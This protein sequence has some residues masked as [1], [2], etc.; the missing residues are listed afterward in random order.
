[1]VVIPMPH[2][3]EYEQKL[4]QCDEEF[5]DLKAKMSILRKAGKETDIAELLALDFMPLVRMA[6]TTLAQ[7]DLARVRSLLQCVRSEL[8]ESEE[9]TVFQ[10]SIQ[11]IEQAYASL[12]DGD[13]RGARDAYTHLITLYKELPPDFKRSLYDASLELLKRIEMA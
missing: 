6:R 9:G 5:Q 2:D 1:M 8:K 7:E 3:E 4:Q 12:R 11:V 13:I 10:Q